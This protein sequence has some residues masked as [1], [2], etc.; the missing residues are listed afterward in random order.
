MPEIREANHRP[1]K[2]GACIEVSPPGDLGQGVRGN[3]REKG[4]HRQQDGA[5]DRQWHK[6]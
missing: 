1:P 5:F 4:R 6:I 2:P 3:E